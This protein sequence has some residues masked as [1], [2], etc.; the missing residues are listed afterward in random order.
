MFD[1]PLRSLKICRDAHSWFN[2]VSSGW[3]LGSMMSSVVTCV[4]L[5]ISVN[6]A[7]MSEIIAFILLYVY[8][9]MGARFPVWLVNS[10]LHVNFLLTFC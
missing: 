7:M 3:D 4:C 1:F 2:L 10:V 6:S 9:R 8:T 5:I